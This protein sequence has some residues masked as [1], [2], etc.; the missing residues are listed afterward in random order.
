MDLS[1]YAGPGWMVTSMHLVHSTLGATV[2]HEPI[3]NFSFTS[4]G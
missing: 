3:V 1:S 4:R 2:R